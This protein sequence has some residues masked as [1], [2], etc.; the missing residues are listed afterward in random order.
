[1]LRE[2]ACVKPSSLD[3]EIQELLDSGKL[4]SHL[5]ESLD[6]VRNIGNF[7]AHPMKCKTTG[8]ILPVE[9]GEAEWNLEVIEALFD[10]FFVQPEMLKQKRAALNQKLE[11]AGKPPMK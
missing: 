3:K 5:A 9:T 8:E 10:F 7:A 1:M 6:S 11:K 2:K 4:P